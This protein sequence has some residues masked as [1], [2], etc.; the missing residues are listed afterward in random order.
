MGGGVRQNS[1]HVIHVSV[2]ED[3]TSAS[4]GPPAD[5]GCGWA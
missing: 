3:V 2:R 1:G 4:S 5:V